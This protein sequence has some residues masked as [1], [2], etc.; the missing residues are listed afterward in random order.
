[1][2]QLKDELRALFKKKTYLEK[3]MD[4]SNDVKI[5]INRICKDIH[6]KKIEMM[7]LMKQS[8]LQSKIV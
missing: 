3:L 4:Q 8:I 6:K 5:E 1:M 7:E 2:N